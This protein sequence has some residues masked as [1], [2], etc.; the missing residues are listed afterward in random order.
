MFLP[1]CLF[2]LAAIALNPISRAS[3][4]EQD[5][6]I[7]HLWQVIPT[8]DDAEVKAFIDQHGIDWC[9]TDIVWARKASAQKIP[10]FFCPAYG[11]CDAPETRDENIP[12]AS[13]PI[14]YIR[15]FINVF[16]NDDGSNPAASAAQVAAQMNTLNAHFLP[17]RVQFVYDWRVVNSTAYRVFTDPEEFGMKSAYAVQPDSN[18][19]VYVTDINAGYIG[20]GTFP[21]DPDALIFMGGTIVDDNFFGG[22]EGTLTHEIG[23][24]LGLWHT[25]HGVSEVSQCGACWERADGLNGDITGDFCS[26][27]DPTPRN[28][29]CSSPGGTDPCSGVPWGPT[30]PQNYMGYAPDFC[31]TEFT[32]QQAGRMHCWINDKLRGWLACD[33]P[34]LLSRT[35][36][37]VDTDGDGVD[38]SEDNCPTVYNPCQE[39]LDGDGIGDACD[40]DIDNDGILNAADNCPYAYNPNQINSDG[41]DLGDACDNCPLVSNPD[42]SDID[43]DG[44]GDACD[45]C[46]DTDG[47]GYGDPGFAANTCPI[48]N[49]PSL[50]NSD[51]ADLDGDGVGDLCDNCPYVPNPEQFDENSDGVGDACD[52]FLHIQSY[53]LP[54]GYLGE[55]YFYQLWAV[56]GTEPYDWV[57]FGGDLPFGCVFNGGSVGTITG[58][59]SYKADYYFTIVCRDAGVPQEADTISVVIR[60]V[61]PLPPP[62]TCGD[63]DASGLVTISDAVYL[64]NFI[65]GGGPA[66]SPP[67]SGDVDCSGLVSISDA[68]YL[69]N[70]IFG[71]G[72]APCASCS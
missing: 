28:F 56:G 7:S 31:Y 22:N 43:K 45:P 4:E 9:R 1:L 20:V 23:H 64:V 16:A 29:Y 61:D 71:G 54:D 3:A 57:F 21:W 36:P 46:T 67:E 41:D 68:V 42:Q 15:L 12:D 38:D 5:N 59:P 30:M 48:D 35:N 62:Y 37:Q 13:R 24:C 40:P 34:P 70:F 72:A 50:A 66:P 2:A 6:P 49:C 47:D 51:Q 53:S 11:S 39:D 69:V 52:G 65:F 25:H 58:T 55:P 63:T 32:L 33:V 10:S 60:V 14:T 8:I 27:T 44:F 18:L 19:N 26:D 17:Y